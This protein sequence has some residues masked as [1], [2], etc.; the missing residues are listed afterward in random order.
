MIILK[1]CF[2]FAVCFCKWQLAISSIS[3]ANSITYIGYTQT[4][5]EAH[6]ASYPVG[7][8]SKVL[9]GRDADHSPPSNAE[10]KNEYVLCFLSP[11]RLHGGSG[12]AF[13][14]VD[15]LIPNLFVKP[16]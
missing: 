4:T 13:R 3:D 2:N 5:C 16:C 9:P 11:C 12:T 15:L 1:S 10:V 7:S 14:Q 6:Q 8:R